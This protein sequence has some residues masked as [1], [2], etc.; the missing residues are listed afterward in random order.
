MEILIFYIVSVVIS[1]F[2]I[3]LGYKIDTNAE[4]DGLDVFFVLFPIANV[5]YA[6]AVIGL[7]LFDKIKFATHDKNFYRKFFRL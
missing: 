4:P 7:V 6:I 5:V 3:R 2:V 1:W